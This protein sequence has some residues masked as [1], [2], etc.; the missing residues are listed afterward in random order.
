MSE[1]TNKTTYPFMLQSTSQVSKPPPPEQNQPGGSNFKAFL[2]FLGWTMGIAALLMAVVT[3]G[4]WLM[5]NNTIRDVLKLDTKVT[6]INGAA[7]IESIKRVNKQIFIEHYNVVDVD[8]T[9][10]PAGWLRVLPIKQTFVVLL[11]G[12]VP[13]GFDLSQLTTKDVWISDDHQRIQL[14]LPPPTIFED[15]VNIDFEHSRILA[16]DDT[17][18]DFICQQTI[19]AYQK[20]ILPE[21]RKLLVNA[22]E[23]SG[24]LEEVAEDGQRYYE[25]LLKSLGFAEVRVI[26]SNEDQ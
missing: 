14:I 4:G 9:E 13:A 15:N 2:Q 16:Q 19:E 8:Y 21:G 12:R 23:Q 24:I 22:S 6:V 20:Q 3:L 25:Q 10:A 1:S 5:L 7:V 11:R 17:C 26:V 18:P